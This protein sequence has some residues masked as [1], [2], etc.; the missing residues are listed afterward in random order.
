MKIYSIGMGVDGEAQL[1]VYVTDPRGQTIKT[2]RPMHSQV[3]ETLLTKFGKET[4]GKFW[5]ATSGQGLDA[6]FHEIDQLEKTKIAVDKFTKYSE[7]YQKY[8]FWGILFYLVSLIIGST[9]LRRVP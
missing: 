4:G 9:W 3:N 7:H 5:R 6:V 8:L 2:Y 1:P